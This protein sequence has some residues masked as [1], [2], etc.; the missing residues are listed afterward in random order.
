MMTSVQNG[1]TVGGRMKADRN[2]PVVRSAA[3]ALAI[4]RLVAVSKDG[5]TARE[6]SDSL[7]LS[8]PTTYH[9]LHTLVAEGFLAP[10]EE[11]RHRLGPAVGVLSEGFRRQIAPPEQLLPALRALS[12]ATGEVVY[13]AGWS[14]GEIV[15][16]ARLPGQH[17][18]SVTEL[19][20]GLVGGAHARATGKLLL[21][22]A[23]PD[24]RAVYLRRHPPR[25]LT[26]STLIGRKELEQETTRIRDCGYAVDIEEFAEGVCCLAA[27]AARSDGQFAI[28]VSAPKERFLE[29]FDAYLEA[30]LAATGGQ[31]QPVGANQGG[32]L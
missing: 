26:R 5:L 20:L 13:I 31:A 22:L 9:L 15:I 32:R 29:H 19:P 3:R 7:E 18:V 10:A 12:L 28:A 21:A 27:P 11:R 17:P 8:R 14:G 24:V 1:D 4:L 2:R 30:A 23:A 25:R 6:I 16:L